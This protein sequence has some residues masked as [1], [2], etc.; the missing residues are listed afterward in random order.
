MRL[1]QLFSSLLV[2][3]VVMNSN[4]AGAGIPESPKAAEAAPGLPTDPRWPLPLK[5]AGN[6]ILNSKAEPVLLRGVNAA[7]LEWT[8]NGEGHILQSVNVAI[9]DWL[10]NIIRL[11]LSQ[12]R[13]FGKGPEQND[14]GADYRALVD[15]L[16]TACATQGCYIILDLHWSNCGEW[17]ANIGQ[18]SLPDT[19]S[20]TF[21]KDIAARYKNHPAVLFGL[22]NEPRDVSWDVWLNGGVI[23]E[24]PAGRRAGGQPRTYQAIGM[25]PLLEVVRSTGAKNVVLVGGLD[26]AYDFSGILNGRELKDPG[27]NGVIYD[28]HAYPFKGDNADRWIAKMEK[29]AEQLP[30]FIGEFGGS[31]GPNRRNVGRYRP[32][33]SGDDWLLHIIQ[34]ILDHKW[35]YAAW[36]F[37]PA[38][39]PTLIADWTYKPTPDF[40]VYVRQ[41][42]AGTFPRYTPPPPAPNPPAG[43]ET[44]SASATSPATPAAP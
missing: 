29:A 37:H 5:T 28:N 16:V 24:K 35:S 3:F 8:N 19:N 32:D 26:W 13:W 34:A 43:V 44:N 14:R 6:R 11:P 22:Y 1:T 33:P 25:Q 40:G 7:S 27:G 36:D 38:A 15:A 23:T 30:I 17:G 12:D 41:M 9:R 18:H 31:G 10:V 21:W 20:V 42:L 4:A 2:G 39:G